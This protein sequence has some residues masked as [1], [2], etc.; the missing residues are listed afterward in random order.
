MIDDL[1]FQVRIII[2]LVPDQNI[3]PSG[4]SFSFEY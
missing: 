1:N 4:S 3:Y 2:N